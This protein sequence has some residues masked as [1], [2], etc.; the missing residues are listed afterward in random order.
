MRSLSNLM[1]TIKRGNWLPVR[2]NS[3]RERQRSGRDS[4]SI[5]QQASNKADRHSP[6]HGQN[7]ATL[8]GQT[9]GKSDASPWPQGQMPGLSVRQLQG[10]VQGWA[11]LQQTESVG[12]FGSADTAALAAPLAAGAPVVPAAIS[13]TPSLTHG[14]DE[15]HAGR[16]SAP[17]QAGGKG[18]E[19]E[20]QRE[21][22][23]KSK[24][25]REE[26]GLWQ[27]AILRGLLPSPGRS[28]ARTRSS[29]AA[30]LQ[31]TKASLALP[32]TASLDAAALMPAT[33]AAA[34]AAAGASPGA[35]AHTQH[36]GLK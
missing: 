22:G 23:R 31:G 27:P 16:T 32:S 8:S 35:V 6:Q 1:S 3:V 24:E 21:K 11:G 15:Q 20:K 13:S 12:S 2:W 26:K 34:A 33:A 9:S 30:S 36:Q 18:R 7:A 10:A 5:S 4:G 17:P 19:G 14:A 25:D 29:K 28:Q